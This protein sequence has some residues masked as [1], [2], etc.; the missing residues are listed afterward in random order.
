MGFM[1]RQEAELFIASAEGVRTETRDDVTVTY[2]YVDEDG[3]RHY[4][5][6]IDDAK[7]PVPYLYLEH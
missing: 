1:S 6:V 7:L 3:E 2:G 4:F 5:V